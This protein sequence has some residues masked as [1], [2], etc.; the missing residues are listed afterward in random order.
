MPKYFKGVICAFE[1]NEQR[2]AVE[3]VYLLWVVVQLV[4]AEIEDICWIWVA[5]FRG[6]EKDNGD[7]YFIYNNNNN[8]IIF[9]IRAFYPLIEI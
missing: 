1:V 5:G 9:N 4:H 3:R 2:K 7:V 8:N 6:G